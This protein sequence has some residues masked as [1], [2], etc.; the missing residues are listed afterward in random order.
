MFKKYTFGILLLTAAG[1]IAFLAVLVSFQGEPT[2]EVAPIVL[3]RTTSSESQVPADSEQASSESASP[4]G[5]PSPA[6]TVDS[7][8]PAGDTPVESPA[9]P[10]IEQAPAPVVLPEPAVQHYPATDD[11]ADDS[12][13]DDDDFE[14]SSD[15]D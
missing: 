2:E 12:D 4:A 9:P 8:P 5:P 15:D 1:I 11:D 6:P 14:D 7:L 10:V 13:T 3:D